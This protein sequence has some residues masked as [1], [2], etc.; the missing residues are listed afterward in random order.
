MKNF[1]LK[2][3]YFKNLFSS[4][5]FKLKHF[6]L[7][8]IFLTIINIGHAQINS[9]NVSD[10]QLDS[11]A[12]N[13]DGN[14]DDDSGM[15]KS[16]NNEDVVIIINQGTGNNG[17]ATFDGWN[18]VTNMNVRVDGVLFPNGNVTT[19][20]EGLTGLF[21][22]ANLNKHYY[23]AINEATSK[24]HV[25]EIEY[26]PILQDYEL[27]IFNRLEKSVINNSVLL[28]EDR[29]NPGADRND[30]LEGVTYNPTN[31]KLYFALEHEIDDFS[32][33]VLFRSINSYF[34]FSDFVNEDSIRVEEITI[35]SIEMNQDTVDFSGLYHLSKIAAQTIYYY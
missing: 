18:T 7:L 13:N 9:I 22:T 12:T 3:K 34:T 10:Y 28:F 4:Q 16:W 8:L 31:G 5:N 20:F 30:G 21:P 24:L 33:G 17:N 1:Y 11:N 19:D 6:N 35:P 26:D 2:A 32:D 14:N 29:F 27:D 25:F 23:G 15:A